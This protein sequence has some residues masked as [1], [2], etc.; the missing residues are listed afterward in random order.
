MHLAHK[1][2][3]AVDM[4]TDAILGMTVQTISGD[5]QSLLQPVGL[6]M[7]EVVHDKGCH[8]NATMKRLAE[9]DLRSYV[10]APGRRLHAL[11][12]VRAAGLR[13]RGG[14]AGDRAPRAGRA[15]HL[16][17]RL[18]LGRRGTHP[19]PAHVIRQ[20]PHVTMAGP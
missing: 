5:T 8:S 10:S 9:D 16:P 11:G 18:P 19:R 20:A 12:G 4:D 2:A 7:G 1:L 3:H 13:R 15:V 6:A 14:A 17:R